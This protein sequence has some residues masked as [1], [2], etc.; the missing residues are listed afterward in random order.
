[1]S[2]NDSHTEFVRLLSFFFLIDMKLTVC[3]HLPRLP[4]FC[5]AV[6]CWAAWGK[7]QV[8]T[9]RK[10]LGSNAVKRQ[11]QAQKG[12]G[13]FCSCLIWLMTLNETPRCTIA[14]IFSPHKKKSNAQKFWS[15]CA[16]AEQENYFMINLSKPL[17]AP[18][19]TFSGHLTLHH[20][21][22]LLN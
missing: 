16:A 10:Y 20:I 15:F 9:P 3:H 8:T 12:G 4:H 11:I 17:L 2:F 22:V 6:S 1:M 13:L 18:C 14:D 19:N 7:A 5:C 21:F